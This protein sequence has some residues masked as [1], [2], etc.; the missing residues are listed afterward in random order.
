MLRKLLTLLAIL[1]G[2]TA[3]ATP[4]QARF[5]ALEEAQVSLSEEGSIQC[6]IEAGPRIE[7]TERQA[8]RRVEMPRC[9]VIVIVVKT[10]TVQLG[11][12][13]SRE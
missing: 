2:L 3:V 13:R 12:D 6:R 5:S 4:A 1:S 11:S 8:R 10:P 9:P 7:A